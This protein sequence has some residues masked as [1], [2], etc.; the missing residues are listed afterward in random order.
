[1]DCR[2]CHWALRLFGDRVTCEK[3]GEIQ[4][5][6]VCPEKMVLPMLPECPETPEVLSTEYSAHDH[7]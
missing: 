6:R 4:A 2:I 3:F 7:W 1:M 5:R